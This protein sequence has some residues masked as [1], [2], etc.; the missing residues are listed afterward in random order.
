MTNLS[1][2]AF[3]DEIT[4]L[5]TELYELDDAVA[6]Q[7]VVDAQTAD[8]F[9]KHDDVPEMRTLERAKQ[10]A[11]AL[12]ERKQNKQKTQERQQLRQRQKKK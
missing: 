8:Y 10:E 7:I 9:V 5:L 11:V 1:Y 3:L 12:F 4:T 2:E 6:I